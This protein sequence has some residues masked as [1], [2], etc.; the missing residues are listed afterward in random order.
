MRQERGPVKRTGRRPV[1]R[2][3]DR[4]AERCASERENAEQVGEHEKLRVVEGDPRGGVRTRR[5]T[6]YLGSLGA[7]V[8]RDPGGCTRP[9]TFSPPTLSA[10]SRTLH[11]NLGNSA[12]GLYVGRC[13]VRCAQ[14]ASSEDP[15]ASLLGMVEDS[16]LVLIVENGTV[17]LI[18]C[19]PQYAQPLR[20]D[21][22]S[23]P[24]ARNAGDA[25]SARLRLVP[26]DSVSLS[27]LDEFNI[28]ICQVR[29]V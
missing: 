29:R 24:D 3:V 20:P 18:F 27:F 14:C 13:R 28:G 1:V 8:R 5:V 11:S 16:G 23:S 26:L 6:R 25:R 7:R 19:Q 17:K 9:R 10:C 12:M 21:H 2:L 4:D 15:S 22:H